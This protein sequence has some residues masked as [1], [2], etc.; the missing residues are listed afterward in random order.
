MTKKRNTRVNKEETISV[1]CTTQQKEMLEKIAAREG[2][3]LST[4]L[5]RLGLVEAQEKK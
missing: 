3:G 1:R 5:L 4:W 2:L